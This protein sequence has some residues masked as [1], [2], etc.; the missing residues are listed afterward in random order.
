M[1]LATVRRRLSRSLFLL[2]AA[3]RLPEHALAPR[4]EVLCPL[5]RDGDLMLVLVR[6]MDLTPNVDIGR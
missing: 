5:A 2:R 4:P 3:L 6:H 1:V